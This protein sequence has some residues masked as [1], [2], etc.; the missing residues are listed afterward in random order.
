M[1]KD[2]GF[3]LR[4]TFWNET[5]GYVILEL[6]CFDVVQSQLWTGPIHGDDDIHM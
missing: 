5:K 1:L 6:D 2:S 3:I 4:L